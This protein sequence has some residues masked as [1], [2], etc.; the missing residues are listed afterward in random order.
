[1]PH[2]ASE[3]ILTTPSAYTKNHYLYVQEAGTLKSLEPHISRREQL[4]SCLFF[5]VT[6]GCGSLVLEGTRHTLQVG[7][8]VFIDCLTPY[9]HESSM[10]SPWSLM[11]VHFHGPQADAF[12]RLYREREGSPVF[13][14]SSLTPYREILQLLFELQ[15]SGDALSDLLCH[16]YL[17][18]LIAQ[19]FLDTFHSVDSAAIPDKFRNIREYLEDHYTEKLSLDKIS[20]IFYI[21]KYHLLREYK[22]LFGTTIQNDLTSRR[23]TKAKSLLRFSKESVESIALSCGFQT[24]SYFIKVF[25]QYE[26]ITPLEYR[27]KW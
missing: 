15:Q 20:E 21:S 3:R 12:Y 2:S 26:N 19:I 8:C 11:W 14:P 24:A 22:R 16:R 23:L 27:R 5:I 9:S 13:R 18:D 1:M 10:E 17:T 6:E 25:K 7:D 4:E